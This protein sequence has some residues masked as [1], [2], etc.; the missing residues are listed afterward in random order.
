MAFEMAGWQ[1]GPE[2]GCPGG[3]PFSN[4]TENTD[5]NTITTAPA[6]ELAVQLY[7][8]TKDPQ[9]L[10]FAVTAYEWVRACLLQPSDLYADHVNRQG[11]PNCSSSGATPRGS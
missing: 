11:V 9:Y 5:R 3:L 7:R 8:I 4:T 1:A 6:A 2:L 10:Q